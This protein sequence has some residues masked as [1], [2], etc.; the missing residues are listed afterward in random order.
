M[1]NNSNLNP[2]LLRIFDYFADNFE[3]ALLFTVLVYVNILTQRMHCFCFFPHSTNTVQ[4]SN[5]LKAKKSTRTGLRNVRVTGFRHGSIITEYEASYEVD[6]T[7]T[8]D[9]AKKSI[10]DAITNDNFGGLQVD[11]KSVN[12]ECKC[13]LLYIFLTLYKIFAPR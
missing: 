11:P 1:L 3:K 5:A 8:S 10:K 2:K 12:A 7:V 13:V 6:S 4:I 9:A